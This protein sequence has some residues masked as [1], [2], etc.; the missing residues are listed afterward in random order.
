[1]KNY[2]KEEIIELKNQIKEFVK[3]GENATFITP[4]NWYFSSSIV[5]DVRKVKQVTVW[6]TV[7][8]T[9]YR[10][11]DNND[12]FGSFIKKVLDIMDCKKDSDSYDLTV[13]TAE[14]L[15]T[16]H[17][18]LGIKSALD[19]NTKEEIIE[20]QKQVLGLV[21]ND[22]GTHEFYKL[23]GNFYIR[24]IPLSEDE[25][26]IIEWKHI[27]TSYY[28][29]DNEKDDFNNFVLNIIKTSEC[30]KDDDSYD[31]IVAVA[32]YLY[33]KELI[34]PT[35]SSKQKELLKIGLQIKN[36]ED[37]GWSGHSFTAPNGWIFKFVTTSDNTHMPNGGE[38]TV[39]DGD[40]LLD[41]ITYVNYDKS[42]FEVFKNKIINTIDPDS[43]YNFRQTYD[44][45][46][47][48][49]EYLFMKEK[50]EKNE[51]K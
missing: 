16:T 15:Y 37:H 11:N 24:S 48:V 39:Y 9:T 45:A 19:I 33:L 34:K 22:N 42:E 5:D 28:Y 32:E 35:D 46:N 7:L 17:L 36:Y 20:E 26:N 21:K 10:T 47:A 23:F 4:N 50:I 51:N 13:A 6:D 1:M 38:L 29:I 49:A 14:Y 27:K 43:A 12:E 40:K 30:N 2:T 3:T 18:G 44:M 31:L 8:N 25:R 41:H